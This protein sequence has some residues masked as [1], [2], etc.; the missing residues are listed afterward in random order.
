M[1]KNTKDIKGQRFGKLVVIEYDHS[2]PFGVYWKCLCDCGKTKITRASNLKEGS[3]RSCGC[4]LKESMRDVIKKQGKCIDEVGKKYGK[5][6]VIKRA[7][8]HKEKTSASWKCLCDCGNFTISTGQE[9]RS[10]RRVS[11]GCAIIEKNKNQRLEYGLASLN[12]IY[13]SYLRRSKE[14]QFEMITKDQFIELTKQ[15]CHYCGRKPAN[16]RKGV[17]GDFVYNGID[18]KN[19]QKGYTLENTVTCCADCNRAKRTM[20]YYEYIEFIKASYL[21][22]QRWLTLLAQDSG[23]SLALLA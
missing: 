16:K 22:Q 2:T 14:K 13:L 23:D 3:T 9:L 21:H 17:F 10:G 12:Q 18:R 7:Y 4:L 5:L 15:E 11:C 1:H 8:L 19:N 6:T 20:S